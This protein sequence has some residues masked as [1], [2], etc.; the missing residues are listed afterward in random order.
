MELFYKTRL[1]LH[2]V[3][4]IVNSKRVASTL[5]Y[6]FLLARSSCMTFST[7]QAHARAISFTV[8]TQ[9]ILLALKSLVS[10]VYKRQLKHHMDKSPL[11]DVD[12]NIT[13]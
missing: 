8:Y 10:G 3:L 1:L 4:G 2:T 6:L 5:I 9:V 13:S 12:N 7:I 11:A